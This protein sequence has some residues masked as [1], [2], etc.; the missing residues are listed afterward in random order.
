[1]RIL[2]KYIEIQF[3]LRWRTDG[4]CSHIHGHKFQIIQRSSNFSSNDPSVITN[5]NLNNPLPRDTILI[6]AGASATLR[7]APKEIST[8]SPILKP[9]PRFV[10]D[11]PGTWFFH[12]HIEWH[13]QAGFAVVFVEAPL[14]AQRFVNN[15]PAQIDANC[16]ALNEPISGN[17]AGHASTT[18]FSGLPLGPYPV[19]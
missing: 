16:K 13:L 5:A 15:I 1:V 6:D 7:C 4:A 19:Y 8:S 2:C 14:I 17:A 3:L 11:N 12:C 18:D 9:S 10:A